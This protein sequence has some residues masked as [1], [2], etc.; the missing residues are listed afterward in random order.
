MA[1][2]QFE[3]AVRAKDFDQMVREGA[4]VDV[5]AV[6]HAR[7]RDRLPVV[8]VLDDERHPV[9]DA[10]AVFALALTLELIA[11]RPCSM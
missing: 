7:R 4:E 8:A 10:C 6:G 11:S 9:G 2:Q 5:G 1:Q 3:I